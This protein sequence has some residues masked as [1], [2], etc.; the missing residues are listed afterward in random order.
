MSSLQTSALKEKKKK[1][2]CI[3]EQECNNNTLP[4]VS[5]HTPRQ[6]FLDQLV[7]FYFQTH[8]Q[9]PTQYQL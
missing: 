7:L 9:G 2:E 3:K 1:N 6:L 4:P 8:A 5:D